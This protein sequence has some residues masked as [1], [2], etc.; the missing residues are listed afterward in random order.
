MGDP[1]T[2]LTMAITEEERRRRDLA[3]KKARR[4]ADPEYRRK[5]AA[6]LKDYRKRNRAHL[7]AADK[8]YQEVHEDQRKRQQAVYYAEHRDQKRKQYAEWAQQPEV[9]EARAAYD[10]QYRADNRKRLKRRRQ[11][12]YA[13]DPKYRLRVNLR[14]RLNASIKSGCKAGSAVRDLGCSIEEFMD[15]IAGM[16]QDGMVWDNWGEWHL[17]HIKPMASFD[18]TDRENFLVCCHYTNFRPLWAEENLRKGQKFT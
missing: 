8:A 5:K 4:Q 14:N 12:R 7:R 9:Q 2:L 18:L 1:S 11:E 13:S 15:Y 3:R 16:F 6:Y 17:D 10:K